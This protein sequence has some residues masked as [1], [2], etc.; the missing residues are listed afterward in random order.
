MSVVNGTVTGGVLVGDVSNYDVLLA[1]A[2]GT[3]PSADVASLVLPEGLAPA[4][5][6]E[7][8]DATL[9]CSCNDVSRGD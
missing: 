4:T 1:M 7:L 8:P 2:S 3:M 5:T 6:T 9:L